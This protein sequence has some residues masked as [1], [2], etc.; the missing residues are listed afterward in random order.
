MITKA[1]ALTAFTA[2]YVAGAASGR[3]RY[4]QIRRVV[5]GVAHDPKVQHLAGEA[6]EFAHQHGAAVTEKITGHRPATPDR[7]RPTVDDIETSLHL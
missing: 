3:E 7:E 2:G 5:L 6:A 1:I 4:E